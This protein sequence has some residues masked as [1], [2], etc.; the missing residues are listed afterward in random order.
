MKK[1]FLFCLLLFISSKPTFAQEFRPKYLRTDDP[2]MKEL[3]EE[4]NSNGW[5]YFREGERQPKA[6]TFLETSRESLGLDE[7]YSVRPLRDETDKEGIRHHTA[8]AC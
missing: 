5:I 6:E 8:I 7:D 3:A 2:V 1:L 4:M